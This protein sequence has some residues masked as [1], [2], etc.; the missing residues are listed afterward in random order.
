MNNTT[1]NTIYKT[2]GEY[3]LKCHF[4]QAP[5]DTQDI[6]INTITSTLE[7]PNHPEVHCM[8]YK[9]KFTSDEHEVLKPYLYCIDIYLNRNLLMRYFAES[10]D[11]SEYLW[12]YEKHISKPHSYS[13]VVPYW[14]VVTSLPLV[15]MQKSIPQ[16]VAKINLLRPFM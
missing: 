3:S 4:C 7:C 13:T 15:Y 14:D 6:S 12:L 8:Y 9:Y 11:H 1:N 2:L 10:P 5:L 16:I